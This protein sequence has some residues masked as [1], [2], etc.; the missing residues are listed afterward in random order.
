MSQPVSNLS[1]TATGVVTNGNSGG[2]QGFIEIISLAEVA[3]FPEPVDGIRLASAIGYTEGGGSHFWHHTRNTGRVRSDLTGPQGGELFRNSIT[4]TV[5]GNAPEV[6]HQVAAML[7]KKVL[8]IGTD[9][10]GRRRLVGTRMR[11]ASVRAQTDSGERFSERP[12]ATFTI[13]AFASH[14]ALFY[15]VAGEYPVNLDG[16]NFNLVTSETGY[17]EV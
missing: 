2:L 5:P 12:A 11:P 3:S 8:A 15:D 1:K 17:T 9:R 4:F 14:P 6:L 10:Q 16:F 7:G 13:E